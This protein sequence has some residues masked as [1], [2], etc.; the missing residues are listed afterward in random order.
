MDLATTE[1]LIRSD[2]VEVDELRVHG[3]FRSFQFVQMST[4]MGFAGVVMFTLRFS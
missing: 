1:L 3:L 2:L 4:W